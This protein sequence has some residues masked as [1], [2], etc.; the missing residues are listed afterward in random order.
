MKRT[1]GKAAEKIKEAVAGGAHYLN[2]DS[3][4]EKKQ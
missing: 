3:N 4:I 1:T 2:I